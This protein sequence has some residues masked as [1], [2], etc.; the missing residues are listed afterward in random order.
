MKQGKFGRS[1]SK[2]NKN[3]NE[4]MSYSSKIKKWENGVLREHTLVWEDLDYA[5]KQAEHSD[6]D[7]YEVRFYN[8]NNGQLV[9]IKP[10]KGN[11][12]QESYA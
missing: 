8:N 9:H 10:I 11:K 12:D 1:T 4:K 2:Q 6:H 7:E 5:I 3:K